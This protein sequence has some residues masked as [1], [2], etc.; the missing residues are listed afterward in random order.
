M[1]IRLAILILLLS[2]AC[3]ESAYEAWVEPIEVKDVTSVKLSPNSPVLMADGKAELRFDVRAS[4]KVT[5]KRTIEIIENGYAVVKDS[6]FTTT[7]T[8]KP[9]R[10]P[11]EA[12]VIKTLDGKVVNGGVFRTDKNAGSQIGFICTINGVN[13]AP[14]Y[15]RLIG[16]PAVNF[17]PV[18]VPVIFHLLTQEDKK[19]LFEGITQEY[20]QGLIAHANDVFAA[21]IVHAPSDADTKVT[22]KLAESAPTGTLLKEKGINR[23]DVS[24]KS[25]YEISDYINKNLIWSPERYLNIYIHPSTYSNTAASPRY[26]LDNGSSLPGLDGKMTKV[27]HASEAVF[28]DYTETGIVLRADEI[29]NFAGGGETRLEYYL[30]GYFGLAPTEINYYSSE[31][32]YVNGDVD[33][34]SD[35][36]TSYPSSFLNRSSYSEEEGA[37]S[38]T[39]D[40]FN[41]MDK[42]SKSTS[43]T[44][45]QALRIRTVLENCPGRMFQ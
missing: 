44:Y 43:L 29:F 36:Y 21:R 4:V 5:D 20:L 2:G 23:V 8:L 24:K 39:Y 37:V 13:S 10:L 26:I 45:E 7:T 30:G 42:Y 11:E 41:I 25:S 19:N 15:V 40:A 27:Q 22:F 3:S 18:E 12:V 38:H 16:R 14:C 34:C 35:T 17:T 28:T 33:Y 31:W 9:D 1:K 32:P 6:V